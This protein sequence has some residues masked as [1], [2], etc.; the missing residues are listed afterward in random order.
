MRGDRYELTPKGMR[1]IGQ[2]ALED[3][4]DQLKQ[5][6]VGR[7]ESD[8]KGMG[9]ERGEDTKRY[10]FGDPFHLHLERT[11]S[12]AIRRESAGVPVK[13]TP[14]D[15]EV[16][17]TR[18]STQASTV[19]MLDVSWSMGLRGS[20][21]AAKKVALALSNL[22]KTQYPRD[23]LYVIG[24]SRYAKEIKADT[25]AMSSVDEYAYGTNMQQAFMLA[26]KLLS[27]HK[28]GNRQIVMISDG[29]PTAHMEGGHVYFE[30]PPSQRTLDV[31]LQ[32]V[33][34]CTREKIVINTFMLERNFYM[35]QFIDQL[36]K[37]N[38]GRAFYTTPEQLGKYVLVD[39]LSNK[40]KKVG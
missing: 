1:K 38:R 34:R 18:Y 36:T 23:S 30:Y 10:E 37:I 5:D 28:G 2:K 20:F 32:E 16:F 31:T 26:R 29:E 22:I 12:N 24:F 7:H 15:F 25:L 13:L 17:Q 39:Y 4:F 27:R 8:F 11:L 33:R 19:L 21:F 40:R 6:R 14:D 35:M 3:I 9:Q